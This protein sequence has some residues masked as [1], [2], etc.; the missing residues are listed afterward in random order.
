[1]RPDADNDGS[2]KIF[3]PTAAIAEIGGA[4]TT[5]VSGEAKTGNGVR[6]YRQNPAM[7]A[8]REQIASLTKRDGWM[9]MKGKA[10]RFVS[11]ILSYAHTKRRNRPSTS[12]RGFPGTAMATWLELKQA[13]G[14]ED[15]LI[16]PDR[17]QEIARPQIVSGIPDVIEVIDIL[18]ALQQR[19]VVIAGGRSAA[20]LDEW[21]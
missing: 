1:M 18:D 21:R 7:S 4:A 16:I 8:T 14:F 20:R 11:G 17:V 12:G 2:K 19:I 9:A 5:F 15:S 6:S 10:R 13:V 3:F